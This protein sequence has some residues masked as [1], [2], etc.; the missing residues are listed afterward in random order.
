LKQQFNPLELIKTH[1]V[2]KQKKNKKQKKNEDGAYLLVSL[3][4]SLMENFLFVL[5][6][7]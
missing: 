6:S 2:T 3:A 7:H 1:D 4:P 5:K